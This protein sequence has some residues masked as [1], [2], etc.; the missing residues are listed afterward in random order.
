MLHPYFRGLRQLVGRE[1]LRPDS[2]RRPVELGSR[3]PEIT[4]RRVHRVE[5]RESLRKYP[6]GGNARTHGRSL[7]DRRRPREMGGLY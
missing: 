1:T 3:F 6:H 2:G 7:Q 4:K 5:R